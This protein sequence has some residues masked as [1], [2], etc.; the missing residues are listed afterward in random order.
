[1]STTL[2]KNGRVITATDDYVADVYIENG[3]VKAIGTALPMTADRVI[4]A[5]TGAVV[6]G[7]AANN[8]NAQ[9]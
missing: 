5:A 7:P 9:R 1:M 8:T 6:V 3:R 2:L 4:D